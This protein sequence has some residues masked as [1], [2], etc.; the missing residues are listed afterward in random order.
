[1]A[2]AGIVICVALIYAFL[3]IGAEP[4]LMPFDVFWDWRWNVLEVMVQGVS[5]SRQFRGGC[6]LGTKIPYVS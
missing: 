4:L 3:F 1:M 5:L 6:C 2:G